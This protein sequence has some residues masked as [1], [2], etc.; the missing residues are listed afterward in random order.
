MKKNLLIFVVLFLAL[1]PLILP[2]LKSGYFPT[3]DGEW[4]VIRLVEMNREV[5]DL[6]IPP[7][8]AGYLN[9]GYGYPLFLFTYPFPFYVAEAFHVAGFGFVDSIKIVF[10]LSIIGSAC[11]MY[12]FG[13]FLW[14]KNGA[15]IATLFYLYDPYRL[16]NL[17]TRGS[18]GESLA[19]VWY[20]L[21]AF[22]GAHMIQKQSFRY[23]GLFAFVLGILITTHNVSALLF[24]PVLMMYLGFVFL[25]TKKYT[26]QKLFLWGSGV[27]LGF[28]VAC[29]FWLPALLEQ[30]YTILTSGILQQF[31]RFLTF[32]EVLFGIGIGREYPLML[33]PFMIVGVLIV[34]FFSLKEKKDIFLLGAI[35]VLGVIL[36]LM[37]PFSKVVWNNMPILSSVDFAWRYLGTG[38]FMVAILIG[39]LGVFKNM[40][41]LIVATLLFLGLAFSSVSLFPK[42]TINYG[43]AYYET[44]DGTTTAFDELMPVWVLEKAKNI[45]SEKV[46]VQQGEGTIAIEENRSQKLIFISSFQTD[47]LVEVNTL[48]FP[49][50]RMFI[51]DREVKPGIHQT[52]GTMEVAISEGV[53]RVRVEFHNTPIRTLANGISLISIVIGGSFVLLHMKKQKGTLWSW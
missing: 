44:N 35:G 43:D 45:W 47:G 36:F 40:R 16:I 34:L 38:S 46:V 29:Y 22:L 13:N 12:L 1:A 39:F 42:S 28:G 19:F 32:S 24:L 5:K 10:V 48:Y 3:H 51:D 8:F 18:I 41:Y 4:A 21:L 2:F 27:L 52:R 20:P 30:K 49:G 26:V 37:T 7:R 15:I 6:Q 23:V 17:Y 9:H 31:D 14:G 33:G 53:H 50:W 11:T 25:N